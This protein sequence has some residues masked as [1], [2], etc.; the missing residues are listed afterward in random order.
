MHRMPRAVATLA[1]ALLAGVTLQA[2]TAHAKIVVYNCVL[3]GRQEVG[4]NATTGSGGGRFVINTDANTVDFWISY[5]GLSSAETAA[6][7]HGSAA[8]ASSPGVNAGVVFPLPAGNPKVGTWNY[9]EV[10]EAMIVSGLCY[11]NIHTTTNPGGEIRGQ[12]VPLNAVLD[13]A[14]E[15]PTNASTGSGWMTATIDTAANTISYY[16]SYTGLTGAVTL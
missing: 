16:L 1:L 5:A 12:I 11:A 2:A 6:H 3:S 7:I 10:Q 13:A 8:P 15:V 14:Q 9:T 4:P